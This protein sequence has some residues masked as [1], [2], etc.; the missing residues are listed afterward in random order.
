MFEYW[1]LKNTYHNQIYLTMSEAKNLKYLILNGNIP[2]ENM[3]MDIMVLK[4]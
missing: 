4:V 1:V 2:P 3:G